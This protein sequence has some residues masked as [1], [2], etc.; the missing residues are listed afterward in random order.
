MSRFQNLRVLVDESCVDDIMEKL[1]VV[2]DIEHEGNVGLDSTN[3]ELCQGT[4]QLG[5]CCLEGGAFPDHLRIRS[6]R[7]SSHDGAE[8]S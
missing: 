6:N 5:G 8:A 4:S 3:S 1:W 7:T 2:E